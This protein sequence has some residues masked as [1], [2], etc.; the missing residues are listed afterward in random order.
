MNNYVFHKD[1]IEG[2]IVRKDGS[3]HSFYIDKQDYDKVKDY[4]WK[5]MFNGRTAYVTGRLKG[6]NK[7]YLIHRIILSPKTKEK[8][9]HIDGNGLNNRRNN[10]RLCTYTQNNQN[11]QIRKDNST[12]VKGVRKVKSGKYSARIQSNKKRINLGTFNTLE[13]AKEAYN[14][15]AQELHKEFTRYK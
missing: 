3:K 12:G 5:I 11:A 7:Q 1:Y 14:K 8:I 2:I 4:R 13:E 9:D 10:I 15:K 6:S